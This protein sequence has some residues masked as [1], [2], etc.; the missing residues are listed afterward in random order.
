MS[1]RRPSRRCRP[2]VLPS[3]IVAVCLYGSASAQELV[4]PPRLPGGK[5][6]VSDSSELLL[7]P[8]AALRDGVRI[9][10]TPPRIDFLY[11]PQQ[12]YPGR[13]WS[14]WGDGLYWDGK[15]YSAIG[16]H[17]APQGN[18]FVFAYNPSAQTL[19][20][21]VD[22]ARTLNLPA[23]HYAPGKIHSRLDMGSDGWLYFATHRGSTRVTTDQY[24]YRGDWILRHNPSTAA[25]EIV[26]QGPVPKHC[27]P[28]SVLDPKRLIFYGG[29]AAGD[30][31]TRNVM[32]FA[33]DIREKRVRHSA[34]NGPYRCFI[35]SAST[36]RVYYCAEDEA[37]LMRYDPD[38]GQ[39][40]QPTDVRIGLRAATQETPDGYVYTV[41][42]RGDGEL[43]RFHTGTEQAESLGP[44]AIGTQTYIT[45]LDVDATGRYVYYIPGAHG[46]SQQD[47]T[48]IVQFDTRTRQKK[49]LAFLHPYY[50]KHYGYTPIGTYG[51]A[52][53]D[54]GSTLFVTWNG[55]RSG[56]DRRGR[57]DFD[58]CAL[59]AIH[60]PESERPTSAAN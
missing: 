8:P 50:Q 40:P 25:T 12:E 26:A 18:A 17:L 11:Y 24:H 38:S 4:F 52:L 21:L 32:F 7:Q 5:T 59:T 53:S 3:M 45:S 23:G 19:T 33:Y 9:A 30:P 39:P 1:A 13:P 10:G 2:G 37:P 60:I 56:P 41:S 43:W 14:V 58:T 27:I 55:N 47:G 36:G 49:V 57:F 34:E 42:G 28:T 16:D 29:T 22:V 48:P 6:V 35:F 20:T 54:D 51:V 31:Q 46:G 44:A 15:Y